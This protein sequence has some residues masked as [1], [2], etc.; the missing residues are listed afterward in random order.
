M[1]IALRSSSNI[2]L[3]NP[4]LCPCADPS[5]RVFGHGLTPKLG[6]TLRHGISLIARLNARNISILLMLKLKLK[7][8]LDTILRLSDQRCY[9]E[10]IPLRSMQ[11]TSLV[12]IPFG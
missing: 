1:L 3:T 6:L 5:M 10:Y 12:L 11:W 2:I 9:L 7:F 4:S 8:A